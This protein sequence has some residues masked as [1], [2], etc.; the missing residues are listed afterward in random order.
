MGPGP[1]G[2]GAD[3]PVGNT[4]GAAGPNTAGAAA[5]ASARR[6]KGRD[7]WVNGGRRRAEFFVL[8]RPGA[9]V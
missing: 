3:A 8:S 2:D 4:P 9:D 6:L 7:D 5:P 1:A